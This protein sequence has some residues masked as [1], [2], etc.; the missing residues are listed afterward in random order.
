MG[1]ERCSKYVRFWIREVCAPAGVRPRPLKETT[2][3]DT[4][5]MSVMFDSYTQHFERV[6]SD[7]GAFDSLLAFQ[8]QVH[9]PGEEID[10][11]VSF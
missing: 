6:H 2:L 7:G 3:Y 10:K 9:R 8:N 5:G 11:C 1:S 4:K